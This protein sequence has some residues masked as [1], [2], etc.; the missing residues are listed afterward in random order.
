[1]RKDYTAN[2][3][4]NH[5]EIPAKINARTGE[6]T[7]LS[8]LPIENKSNEKKFDLMKTFKRYNELAWEL[9]ETQTTSKEFAIAHKLALKARAYTNSLQPLNC[10]TTVLHIAEELNEDRRTV[11][12]KIDKLFKLG[13]LAKFEVY[14]IGEKHTKY[15]VFNPYLAFNGKVI[16]KNVE[17]LFSN[18][19]YAKMR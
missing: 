8:K 2:I 5:D 1:M 16:K 4:L 15:W 11:M 12:K 10:D 6:V 13:V 9:L 7:Q 14:E 18:T 17:N 3:Q 19:S